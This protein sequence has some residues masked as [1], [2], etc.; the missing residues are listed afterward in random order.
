MTTW[1]RPNSREQPRNRDA[2]KRSAISTFD[3]ITD[4]ALIAELD[5]LEA[6]GGGITRLI[7]ETWNEYEKERRDDE[8]LRR[9]QEKVRS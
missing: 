1:S 2:F 6:Q 5:R 3:C 9:Y 7:S 4:A 8:Q